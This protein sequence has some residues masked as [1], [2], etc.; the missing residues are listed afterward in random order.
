MGLREGGGRGAR[1]VEQGG[2]P[3]NDRLEAALQPSPS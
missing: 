3:G 1:A 2:H